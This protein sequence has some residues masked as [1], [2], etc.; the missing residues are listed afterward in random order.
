[1]AVDTAGIEAD[2]AHLDYGVGPRIETSGLQVESDVRDSQSAVIIA[3]EMGS[4]R[5]DR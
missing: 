5:L 4:R 3:A 1:M 2:S